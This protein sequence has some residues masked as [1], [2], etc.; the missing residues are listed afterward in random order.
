MT[1]TKEKGSQRDSVECQGY[2]A[3]IINCNTTH[4][5][6]QKPLNCKLA[7]YRDVEKVGTCLPQLVLSTESLWGRA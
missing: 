1:G 5:T 2:L 7:G 3:P 4:N 6:L